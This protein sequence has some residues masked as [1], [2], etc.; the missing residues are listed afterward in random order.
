MLSEKGIKIFTSELLNMLASPI[1]PIITSLGPVPMHSCCMSTKSICEKKTRGISC[2][3]KDP[4][5]RYWVSLNH[6]KTKDST[7]DF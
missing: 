4:R 7:H 1:S 5:S 6:P 2:L 3:Y